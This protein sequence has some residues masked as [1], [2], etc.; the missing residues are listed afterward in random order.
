MF[1]NSNDM[2][3]LSIAPIQF[4]DSR[5]IIKGATAMNQI[6]VATSGMPSMFSTW[7]EINDL[8]RRYPSTPAWGQAGFCGV[9]NVMHRRKA[10]KAGG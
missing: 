2:L 7:E 3:M 5:M 9:G 4:L 10:L 6:R 8:R 1:L